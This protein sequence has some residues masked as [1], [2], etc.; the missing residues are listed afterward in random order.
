V[1]T[2]ILYYSITGKNKKLAEKIHKKIDGK[3]AVVEDKFN[4]KSGFQLYFIGSLQAILS[5]KTEIKSFEGI[6]AFEKIVVVS[7][8]WGGKLPPA[9]QTL[10]SN[11]KLMIKELVFASVSKAGR[12][13]RSKILSQIEKIYCKKPSSYLF[14]KEDGLK[15]ETLQKKLDAFVK[16]TD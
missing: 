4:D 1:K 15:A 6:Q 10:L 2:L 13:N 9:I 11:Y 16:K 12:E 3:I 5:L 7:P 14:L 8:V